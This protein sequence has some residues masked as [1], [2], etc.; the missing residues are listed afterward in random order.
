MKHKTPNEAS[1]TLNKVKEAEQ[2]KE[3]QLKN[4]QV[5]I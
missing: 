2:N 3:N 1:H 4:C 5:K